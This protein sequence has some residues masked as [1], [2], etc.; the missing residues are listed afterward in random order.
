MSA[1]I[2]ELTVDDKGTVKIKQFSD[3]TK[4]A[5]EQ[6][7]KGPEEA[8]GPLD[9]LRENWVGVTA[10]I[11]L[12]TAAVYAVTRAIADH[13]KEAAEAEDIQ[14]RLGF[15]VE[16]A[17]HA[18]EYYRGQT[19][20]WAESIMK[21][22]RFSDEDA[23][24]ALTQM[25]MYTQDMT[26]A[27][28][29]AEL[30][31]DMSVRTGQDLYSTTRMIGMVL[32]GNVEIVGRWIPQ[33]RHLNETLGENAS[34]DEK[35]AAAWKEMIKLFSGSKEAD[36]ETYTGKVK[37]FSNSWRELKESIGTDALPALKS[38]FDWLKNIVDKMR[39]QREL[40]KEAGTAGWWGGWGKAPPG[41]PYM[42][43]P[44]KAAF[45]VEEGLPEI[46]KP[47]I[48]DP[49]VRTYGMTEAE[50]KDRL[51][52]SKLLYQDWLENWQH[53]AEL[54]QADI[55]AWYAGVEETIQATKYEYA[56]EGPW[57]EMD[58]T[59]AEYEYYKKTAEAAS[60]ARQEWVAT[61]AETPNHIRDV[62]KMESTWQELGNNINQ[63]W[64]E[65]V[66]GIV[67]GTTTIKDAFKNMATGMADVF[68]SSITK[69]IAN[70]I[71]F[72]NVQGTYKSGAGVIGLIG[73]LFEAQ[74]GFSGWVNKPT[75][76][77]TGEGGERELI[78]ITPESKMGGKSPTEGGGGGDI[79]IVNLN[80]VTDPNTFVKI[81][82]PVVKKLSEQSAAEARRFNRR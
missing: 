46:K 28:E 44:S 47:E 6:M 5:L 50:L 37:Q 82:G 15:A 21:A 80:Q 49:Y 52:I 59:K 74:E 4:K 73:G 35:A 39:E 22:T 81:Y 75:A 19:D 41:S 62:L 11:A 45:P 66:K 3:E 40:A 17:G 72:Q 25:L 7:K 27:Q 29:G 1:I 71:L 63:V 9:S 10:K 68:I 64:S 20:R 56:P 69:M 48:M 60:Q 65:N 23:R 67:R 76:F 53:D 57:T 38:A 14:H 42:A 8:K 55:Q 2:I 32:T 36:I 77:L 79:Y 13:V 24:S 78:N 26:K 16:T 31:M 58:L 33:L 34:L 61:Y 30:A 12:A 54:M 70:Y 18:W 51:G 43:I